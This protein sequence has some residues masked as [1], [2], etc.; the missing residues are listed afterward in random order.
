MTTASSF[1]LSTMEVPVV[2]DSMEMASPYHGPTE[3]F[4]I[5]IDVMEDQASNPDRDMTA[6]DEYIGNSHG[7]SYGHEHSPDEDMVDDAAEPSMIDAD[8][9]RETNQNLEMQYEGGRTFEAEMLEDEYDEDIDAPV[10]E[11]EQ[12]VP[13]SVELSDT[14][15]LTEKPS[16]NDKKSDSANGPV[17]P[18]SIETQAENLDGAQSGSQEYLEQAVDNSEEQQQNEESKA[19]DL[20]HE[21]TEE[22]AAHHVEG[23]QADLGTAHDGSHQENPETSQKAENE[24]SHLGLTQTSFDQAQ[25]AQVH[26]QEVP[27]VFDQP[28]KEVQQGHE[29]AGHPPLHSVKVYYQDNEI[30]LFPPREGDS[31]ET[32]FL[33][34]EGLAY[35]SFGKLFEAC[36]EV[37]QDHINQSEVLVVDIDPL[38]IQITEDSRE[39]GKVTL[40]Q[41][42]DVYLQLC[43][44]DGIE[45][46]EA[47]YLTLSTKLTTTAELSDLL[48]AASEG[49]GLSEIQP[50]EVYPE[51][52]GDSAEFDETAQEQ[53]LGEPQD[54]PD[55]QD[56]QAQETG[57]TLDDQDVPNTEQ[58]E[59]AAE[60][61][62]T[63]E[64]PGVAAA[65]HEAD[66]K[67]NATV[68]NESPRHESHYSEEQNTESTSTVE[69]LPP[70][71]VAEEQSAAGEATTDPYDGENVEDEYEYHEVEEL[72]DTTH[73]GE[74]GAYV[75]A[76]ELLDSEENVE[77]GDTGELTKELGEDYQDLA[78]NYNEQQSPEDIAGNDALQDNEAALTDKSQ[79][80]RSSKETEPPLEGSST[81]QPQEAP[82]LLDHSLGTAEEP[83]STADNE[84]DRV[85][86]ASEQG[87]LE[88]GSELTSNLPANGDEAA[89]LPFDDEDYLDLGFGVGQDG[90]E[91]DNIAA[92]SLVS[93]K[94]TRDPEDELEF[95]D[96]PTPGAKRSRSS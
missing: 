24:G 56:D 40:K 76:I 52:D 41:I 83:D 34:D 20:I 14:Q 19:T 94:R 74:E 21:Y 28:D 73:Y 42:V 50:W 31:T 62:E 16:L 81:P 58:A 35:E 36:R 93:V 47:L 4:E 18:S 54:T 63:V 15:N 39:T 3:D 82:H 53:S 5:D 6:A 65:V 68:D 61:A 57:S 67:A 48:L 46:S 55:D 89:D 60:S 23:E 96:S 37:L 91:E 7:G 69:P 79:T 78:L 90:F 87:E 92:S 77:G 71:D 85:G 11:H 26:S 86:D 38:S 25:E 2:D 10:P 95:P 9:F 33:E 13:A 59:P 72:G 75:D 22:V 30:S 45:T 12:G 88:G 8:D 66:S 43:H 1:L 70:A 29:S 27:K 51:A 84:L 32:F 17:E 80:Q 64:A 49:K 44:N